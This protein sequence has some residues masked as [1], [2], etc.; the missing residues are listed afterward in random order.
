MALILLLQM[1]EERRL[2][3]AEQNVHLA[4][5]VRL[6]GA[7]ISNG[8]LPEPNG[9]F[10]QQR[11]HQRRPPVEEEPESGGAWFSSMFG[12][13]ASERPKRPQPAHVRRQPVPRIFNV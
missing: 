7:L 3:M 13:F 11:T 1:E 6:K 2:S 12:F 4:E 10:H 5:I 9:K 8:G